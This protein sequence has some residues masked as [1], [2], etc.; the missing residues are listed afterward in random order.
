MK[1]FKLTGFS[2]VFSFTLKSHIKNKRFIITTVAFS[3]ILMIGITVLLFIY[4]GSEKNKKNNKFDDLDKAYVSDETGFGLDDID[5]V[6]VSDETG[7]GIPDY[8]A[9]FQAM[10]NKELSNVEFVE[11]EDSE[12]FVKENKK[13][14]DMIVINQYLD[15]DEYI[16]QAI[17]GIDVDEK[18]AEQFANLLIP[19]FEN[20]VYIKSGLSQEELVQ[21]LVPV[22]ISVSRIGE[23]FNKTKELITIIAFF[24]MM[25]LIYF[26]VLFYGQAICTE[27]SLEKTSK[28]VEQMLT[29][30]TPYALLMGKILAN[31]TEAILQVFI[32]ILSAVIGLIGGNFIVMNAY[33]LESN[34]ITQLFD[35]LK[36]SFKGQGFSV[37]AIV[38]SI[39]LMLVSIIFYMIFA[40]FAG[41]LVTKPEEASNMQA[42]FIVP[43][44]VSYMI[45]LMTIISGEGKVPLIMN[46][47]P[48]T[49]AM[50]APG[51]VLVG[52]LSVGWGIIVLAIMIISSLLLLWLAARIYKGLMFYSG[53]K[54]SF[55]NI[56]KV[57]KN[58]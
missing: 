17:S 44:V 30:V 35:I 6:Y 37:A 39:V 57:A 50:S 31:I 51:I 4:T 5:K 46:L 53:S 41:S 14:S 40:G 24:I 33:G 25:F 26:M 7:F 48:F 18:K 1:S 54:L 20:Q 56:L 21:I 52:N 38:I 8:S 27:V 42:I 3:L 36:E 43:I 11:I 45:V 19:A 32:W 16:I 55:K 47:I 29:S 15:N 23:E 13:K 2:K 22:D 10:G 28:L 12:A 9:Y 49:G 34:I 58:K